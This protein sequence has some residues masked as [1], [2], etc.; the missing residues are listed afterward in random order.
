MEFVQILIK[1]KKP[2]K[3]KGNLYKDINPKDLG[4]VESV[5]KC[6]HHRKREIYPITCLRGVME[7]K[8]WFVHETNSCSEGI[9]YQLKHE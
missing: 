7:I 6:S 9:L 8:S 4:N 1:L 5:I 2:I 3:I